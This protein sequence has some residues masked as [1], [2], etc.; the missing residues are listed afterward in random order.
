[1]ERKLFS[2]ILTV[3][4]PIIMNSVCIVNEKIIG[5]ANQGNLPITDIHEM[6]R[7]PLWILSGG[8][9]INLYSFRHTETKDLDLKILLTGD[10]SVD[11]HELD[12]VS[13]GIK[14]LPPA[15]DWKTIFVVQQPAGY[16][17]YIP[18]N[19][20]QWQISF[21]SI[22]TYNE[23][24]E[25][26]IRTI[27]NQTYHL[28]YE[29]RRHIVKEI[30]VPFKPKNQ[31]DFMTPIGK[32]NTKLRDVINLLTSSGFSGL[33]SEVGPSNISPNGT[34]P[35]RLTVPYYKAGVEY[36]KHFPYYPYT[37]TSDF[38]QVTDLESITN[39]T[40]GFMDAARLC[41][42]LDAWDLLSATDTESAIDAF[43]KLLDYTNLHFMLRSLTNVI[44]IVNPVGHN[45][46]KIDVLHEGV[47]DLFI[48]PSA[49]H[50]PSSKNIYE[51]K[52]N[53][54]DIPCILEQILYCNKQISTVGY[55]KIPTV[56]WI[57]RDQQRMLFHAIRGVDTAHSGWGKNTFETRPSAI[58]A[59]KYHS[60]VQGLIEAQLDAFRHL[61][62]N[63]NGIIA[64]ITEKFNPACNDITQCGPD[65]F[66][67][68]LIRIINSEYWNR[69]NTPCDTMF[70]L[71]GHG[72]KRKTKTRKT[73][74]R[75]TKPEIIINKV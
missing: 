54:G 25:S 55:V 66:V 59:N 74:T 32:K 16:K 65:A 23:S 35:I 64:K 20:I 56:S 69:L 4:Q 31:V 30:L 45:S 62:H 21:S 2:S 63:T 27:Q 61:G 40:Q 52:T 73:K 37:A 13:A 38:K 3:I 7:M 43:L 72:V 26:V 46:W 19:P 29:S 60:K 15:L 12:H 53:S 34:I 42:S 50:K 41:D 18:S 48:D 5:I 10:K 68:Y 44:L 28:V 22:R 6:V 71:L 70:K 8:E 36:Y 17:A 58:D 47:V 24:L 67:S 51:G 9:A 11:P 75:K 39:D 33:A 49:G 57:L 1:M 14:T